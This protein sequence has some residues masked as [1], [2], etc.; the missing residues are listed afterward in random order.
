[1]RVEVNGN[2][3]TGTLMDVAINVSFDMQFSTITMSGAVPMSVC[4]F[5][6]NDDV[7]YDLV[8]W[9]CF[10]ETGSYQMTFVSKVQY[11]W[12][13]SSVSAITGEHDFVSL[14]TKVGV[15]FAALSQTEKK[16]MEM[17]QMTFFDF[18]DWVQNRS[19]C[20][21]AWLM[22]FHFDGI[23]GVDTD[24][25]H[26]TQPPPKIE[27][28]IYTL[29]NFS[30]GSEHY[31]T[32]RAEGLVF[33]YFIDK[34]EEEV[35]MDTF[36]IDPQTVQDKYVEFIT[37]N[38]LAWVSPN[39]SKQQ[40]IMNLDTATRMNITCDKAYFVLGALFTDQNGSVFF[41]NSVSAN[42]AGQV[43]TLCFVK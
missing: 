6:V 10:R 27:T 21:R 43:V 16:Y 24:S 18:L 12:L 40:Y 17:P 9:S 38:D 7:S 4:T 15:P 36:L 11:K 32:A 20:K 14:C 3:I 13:M 31:I 19:V 42:E 8:L 41:V 37:V 35:K 29:K 23:I 28:P 33:Q 1:M 26:S 39:I 2:D 22:T 30:S 5:F 25:F 34:D